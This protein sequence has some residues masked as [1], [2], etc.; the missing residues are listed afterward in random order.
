MKFTKLLPY[1]LLSVVALVACSCDGG[2]NDSP[3]RARI[4]FSQC[5]EDDWR[6][7]MNSDMLREAMLYENMDIEIRISDSNTDQQIAD[8]RKFIEEGIDLLVVCPN[9]AMAITP[10]VEEAYRFRIRGRQ[11]LPYRSGCGSICPFVVAR[12][13]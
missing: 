9:E 3:H 11:Q 13:R 8:I 6:D 5:S 7:K 2:V 12:W 1:I 4:G 10:V